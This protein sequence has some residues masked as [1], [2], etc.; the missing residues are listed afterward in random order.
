MYPS[1]TSFIP[2]QVALSHFLENHGLSAAFGNYPYWYLG[3]TP[4]RY[5][6][7]PILPT[8][9]STLHKIIPAFSLFEIMLF[10]TALCWLVGIIGVAWLAKNLAGKEYGKTAI[11]VSAFIYA[12]F[13]LMPFFF[14]F[15]DGLNLMA[16]SFLPYILVIYLQT[17][18]KWSLKLTVLLILVMSFVLLI[19]FSI[20]PSV[21]IGMA[22]VLLAQTG[23]RKAEEKLK[24]TA[25]SLFFVFLILTLWHTPGYWLILLK[26]PSLAGKG[27]LEVIL[28]ISKLLPTALALVMAALSAKFFKKRNLTRDFCFY[29]LFVFGF[30][31]ILRFVSDPDFWLDWSIYNLELQMGLALLGGLIASRKVSQQETKLT[32]AKIML[33]V[34]GTL[35]FFSGLAVFNKYVRGTFQKDISRTVEYRLGKK[36]NE[37]I[38]P[39]ELVFLSGTTS[40]WLNSLYD[41]PQVRGGADQGSVDPDW[42]TAV[43]E[44]REGTKVEESVKW[45]KKLNISYLVV[46]SSASSEFYHDFVFPEKFE[47][48]DGLKKIFDENGDRVYQVVR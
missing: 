5:L 14:R 30:L 27:R 23:W 2:V 25:W 18:Q 3:T 1:Q 11:L 43:W 16:F 7:G 45:L 28:Q 32:K 39:G 10:L 35:L 26:G 4:F 44:V 12:F 17:L 29:W 33:G 8:F 19:N 31:T 20:L 13:P 46:H 42:R 41:V 21:F 34:L 40:F 15:S 24:K 22:A 38:K 37:V 48:A 9:A 6:T 36:L 47:N